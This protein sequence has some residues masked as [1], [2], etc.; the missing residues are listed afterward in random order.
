MTRKWLSASFC[1]ILA[2]R[3]LLG[4][5]EATELGAPQ[6]EP[7]A[8]GVDQQSRDDERSVL[9]GT[10]DIENVEIRTSDDLLLKA[11]L[12][13]PRIQKFPGKRPAVVF[14]NS[15][16]LDQYE[17]E[18]PARVLA[19]KGYIVLSYATRGFRGSQGSIEVGGP[20]EIRDVQTILDWL[21]ENTRVDAENIG[22][23]GV[24]YGGGISLLGAAFDP[25]IK[26]VAAFS[27]W[28][29]LQESLYGNGTIREVWLNIL[30]GSGD[31]FGQLAP[32]IHELV[33]D[34]RATENEAY[35]KAWARERSPQ[36]YVDRLNAR[37]VPVFLANSYHD[38]LFPPLQMRDFF[39]RLSGPKKFYLDE[40]LH[41]STAI[42]G[43]FGFPSS[44]WSEAYEWFDH[45]LGEKGK[46]PRYGVIF[47]SKK[48]DEV[49]RKFPRVAAKEIVMRPLNRLTPDSQGNFRTEAIVFRGN[50]DSGATS[51][52]P[53]LT[54]LATT[55]IDQPA[56]KYIPFINQDYAAVLQSEVLSETIALRGAPRVNVTVGSHTSKVQLVAYLYDVNRWNKGRL[57]THGVMTIHTPMRD[58]AIYEMNL[59]VIGYD[60]PKGHRLALV[61]DTVDPL[62][63]RPI[64][65][66]YT[67]KVMQDADSPTL[68]QL[69]IGL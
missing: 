11:R 69:P 25:R 30:V 4:S 22:M 60:I 20:K 2:C 47:H 55:Y 68:V 41:A 43:L 46:T 57:I 28:G 61:L 17:Y 27:S 65:G 14:T 52:I 3:A 42:P 19:D 6:Q 38:G 29:N 21:E 48:G 58:N 39:D 53:I 33:K 34:M 18:I 40:G 15:W 31:M 63:T 35:L 49:Y 32:S 51:G 62:Y 67:V 13:T 37:G 9:G 24:S 50:K 8:S 5:A 26:T 36:T 16:T 7:L 56:E 54:D 12:Y 10:F 44:L 23:A 59:G 64:D 45:Y 66:E 1:L